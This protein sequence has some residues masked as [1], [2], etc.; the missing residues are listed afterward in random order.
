MSRNLK[1]SLL[2]VI[3]LC[4]LSAAFWLALAFRFEFALPRAYAKLAF[5][6]WPYVTGAEYGVLAVFAVPQHSWR[7]IGLRDMLRIG[8]AV[9]VSTA[10]LIAARLG[11][12]ARNVHW[13]DL[14]FGVI[15]MNSV[16]AFFGLVA[17][18]VTRRIQGEALERRP[19]ANAQGKRERVLLIGAG[20]AGVLVAR[21]IQARPDLGLD[22]IGFLD[23]DLAKVG[24]R[25][26][27]IAVL[28]TTRQVAEI[29]ERKHV[30]RALITIANA[31]GSQ[32]REIAMRCGEAGLDPK[33]I[34][35]I[36]EIVGD[37]VNLSRIRDVAIE[38]LLG[39][40]PVHLDRTEIAGSIGGRTVLVTGAGG[41]IGSELCRQIARF[42]PK[43]LI[44]VER[45]ENA[46]FEIH[47]ELLADYRELKIE[48]YVADV[49]DVAR[50]EQIFGAG[51]IDVVFHA[52]AHKHVPMMEWNP[53]EALKNNVGGTLAM[54]ELSDRFGVARFVMISTDKAVNPSSVMGA[55]K[56]VAEILC[57]AR[58]Q[59]SKT[60]FITVR[61]GNVLGSNGSVI[62]IFKQ[63]IASGGPVTVTHPDMTRYFMTI[64]EAAQLVLQAGAMGEG[65]EIFILDMGKPVKIVDL[66]TDL[67][68]LSGLVPHEE[69]RIEFT[70]CR[71]GEKLFEE[72]STGSESADKTKHP[73]IFIGRIAPQA[74]SEIATRVT[75]LL[76]MSNAATTGAIRTALAGI[77]PEYKPPGGLE[78]EVAAEPGKPEVVRP[79]RRNTTGEAVAIPVA[80]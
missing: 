39:R 42:S 79:S 37:R 29:V 28:G 50:M 48:P 45:F 57:Q 56:R 23:D 32:I 33:I 78:V 24:T 1:R 11:L 75:A 72:L 25:I 68:R 58:A 4:A 73:K 65:G 80:R 19:R 54:S 41:S 40:E 66:A 76:G 38:D 7:Y 8:A 9:A 51:T 21:E 13:F 3:D 12:D 44:L 20:Q 49:A 69:I 71:P 59:R 27:G 67:I 47:R 46:L 26:C 60:H 74:W 53:G 61:F 31:S 62:P 17:G 55:T 6:I 18:R 14:P 10:A 43:R 70:G 22:A 30:K 15:A 5:H 35:G 36:S 63:Q 34:P 64:P 52:A 2:V 16:L 77:V